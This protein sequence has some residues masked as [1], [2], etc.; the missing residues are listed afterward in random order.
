M[1][2][3]IQIPC[4]NE[5]GQIAATLASIPEEFKHVTE[6]QILVIDDGSKDCTLA[7]IKDSPGLRVLNLNEHQGLA[8]AFFCGI[9]ESLKFDPDIIVNFDADMQYNASDIPRLIQPVINGDANVVIGERPYFHL[10]HFSMAK[11]ILLWI[12]SRLISLITGYKIRDA[13]SGFRAFDKMSAEKLKID[14]NFTYTLESILFFAKHKIK[15]T[16][17]SVTANSPTR[18]SRLFKTNVTYI[19]YSIGTVFGTLIRF[20]KRIFSKTS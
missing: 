20:N 15:L 17:V 7:K 8:Q 11:K 9:K 3:V 19:I 6:I 5:E 14:S 10:K 13:A 2:L 4:Y 18:P 12:G 1:K 16:T